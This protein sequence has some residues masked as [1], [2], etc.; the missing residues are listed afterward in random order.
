MLQEM[1]Q[2]LGDANLLHTLVNKV[3]AVID[4]KEVQFKFDDTIAINTFRLTIFASFLS[5]DKCAEIQETLNKLRAQSCIEFRV[6]DSTSELEE[7]RGKKEIH[8]TKIDP[9]ELL[10][11]SSASSESKVE[12]DSHPVAKKL[13]MFSLKKEDDLIAKYSDVY[14]LALKAQQEGDLYAP[15]MRT[16]VKHIGLAILSVAEA[17]PDIEVIPVG[18]LFIDDAKASD[19][20]VEKMTPENTCWSRFHGLV[21]QSTLTGDQV[22]VDLA[23]TFQ[24][25]LTLD[26]PLNEISKVPSF[27]T[28]FDFGQKIILAAMNGLETDEIHASLCPEFVANHLRSALEIAQTSSAG[29]D[30]LKQFHLLDFNTNGKRPPVFLEQPKTSNMSQN[31]KMT[32]TPTSIA[33]TPIPKDMKF[34][35]RVIESLASSFR[36]TF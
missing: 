33:W 29:G 34:G 23:G 2:F 21:L 19:F 16:A 3:N 12:F 13:Q 1:S 4:D 35:L 30:L 17:R 20:T 26:R 5:V 9:D 14:K 18:R 25:E 8:I 31:L 15:G 28:S 11:F 10:A 6:L 36:P 32:S 22:Y 24:A 27:L 7:N